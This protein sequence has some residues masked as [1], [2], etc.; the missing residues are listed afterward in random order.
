MREPS[1]SHE[2]ATIQSLAKDPDFAALYLNDALS[3][4]S[5]EEL[6]VALR[7][8]AKAF[9][10]VTKL[11]EAAELNANSLYRTLSPKGNPE[12]KSLTALLGAM[13]MR[14]AVQ[15]IAQTHV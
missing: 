9:G 2:D 13:G 7:R 4:G 8:V 15:P 1:C 5:S 11:A 6:L 12:L 10:G 14:L 3:E